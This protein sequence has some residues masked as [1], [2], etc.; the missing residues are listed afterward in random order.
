MADRFVCRVG[1]EQ[2]GMELKYVLRQA[3][4]SGSRLKAAKRIEG[5]ILR[6]GEAALANER[7]SEGDLLE[8]SLMEEK[9]SGVV[10]VEGEVNVLYEDT[11]LLVIDKPP[12]LAVHPGP[13]H[14]T[15]SLANL[16]EGLYVKRGEKRLFRPVNRLD[17]HT[18]GL[19]A[20][21][22]DAH[23]HGALVRQMQDKR[24]QRLYLAVLEGKM[25]P[26]TGEIDLPIGRKAGSAIARCVR[27]DGEKAVSRYAVLMQGENACLA[28][29]RLETGRTHQI[30]VHAAALGHPLVGDFLYGTE[31]PPRCLLHACA[32]SCISPDTGREVRVFAPPPEDMRAAMEEMGLE[33]PGSAEELLGRLGEAGRRA[34]WPE[35]F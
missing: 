31:R 8:V 6:N 13:G 28:A 30:R 19:M 27:E 2:A 9:E 11:A 7:V 26:E 17:R 4:L 16:V 1:A 14:R 12:L 20:V 34:L 3:G 35:G 29:F 15:D 5:G 18:S 33:A 32:L 21:A 23:C 22:K 25:E 10:P 24:F